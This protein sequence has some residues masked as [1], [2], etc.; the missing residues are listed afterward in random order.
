MACGKC[1]AH[2]TNGE[3]PTVVLAGFEAAVCRQATWQRIVLSLAGGVVFAA[4][5]A[6][7]G[8]SAF[9]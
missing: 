2:V 7:K 4:L 6:S 3:L 8:D 5:G 9:K 1:S